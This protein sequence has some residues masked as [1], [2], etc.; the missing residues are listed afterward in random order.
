VAPQK[1]SLRLPP[2][3][4]KI[5]QSA[6][7]RQREPEL[8]QDGLRPSR[9]KGNENVIRMREKGTELTFEIIICYRQAPR[10]EREIPRSI[11]LR[12]LAA[13]DSRCGRSG[14]KGSG[15]LVSVLGVLMLELR[16]VRRRCRRRERRL[17]G[18][19]QSCCPR[20]RCRCRIPWLG[21]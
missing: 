8:V 12:G 1:V 4:S 17:C 7:P 9:E 11:Q 13:A 16:L 20:L 3:T 2:T 15:L 21:G 10:S 5:E 14:R 19:L 18:G 6:K